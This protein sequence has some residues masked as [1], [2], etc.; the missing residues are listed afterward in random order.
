M[1]GFLESLT[2]QLIADSMIV[3]R[4]RE[5]METDHPD[6]YESSDDGIISFSLE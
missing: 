6:D 2:N 1:K 5:E 4:Q 3:A